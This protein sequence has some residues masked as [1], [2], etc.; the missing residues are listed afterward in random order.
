MDVAIGSFDVSHVANDHGIVVQN[1]I[2][3]VSGGSLPETLYAIFLVFA[4]GT[5][6]IF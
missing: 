3:V 5:L 6:I 4:K 2:A 1:D